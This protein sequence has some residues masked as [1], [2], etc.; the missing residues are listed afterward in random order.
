MADSKN[1]PFL[2]SWAKSDHFIYVFLAPRLRQT[3]P[4]Q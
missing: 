3:P 1:D 2:S 4:G